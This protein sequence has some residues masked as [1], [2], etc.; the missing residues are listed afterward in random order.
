MRHNIMLR[1]VTVHY[2]QCM[3]EL[4]MYALSK[5]A[6]ISKFSNVPWLKTTLG[7]RNTAFHEV[8]VEEGIFCFTITLI[9]PLA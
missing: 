2:S 5:K 1:T 8:S 3:T 9:E 6:T 7:T 4:L